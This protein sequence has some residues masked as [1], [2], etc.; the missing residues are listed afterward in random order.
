MKSMATDVKG[1]VYVS[2]VMGNGGVFGLVGLFFRDWHVVQPLMYSVMVCF[3]FG[4][5]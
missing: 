4:H 3:M 5:Q 2:E 1:R